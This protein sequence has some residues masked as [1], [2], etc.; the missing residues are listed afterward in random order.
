MPNTHHIQISGSRRILNHATIS[1]YFLCPYHY[2]LV[3]FNAGVHFHRYCCL[4][5][6]DQ[7]YGRSTHDSILPEAV[8]S[9]FTN[10]SGVHFKLGEISRSHYI[11]LEIGF[12]WGRREVAITTVCTALRYRSPWHSFTGNESDA[13]SASSWDTGHHTFSQISLS[14]YVRKCTNIGYRKVPWPYYYLHDDGVID[15]QEDWR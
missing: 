15:R 12:I 11:P 7:K 13:I 3:C 2:D 10:S 9:I 1:L 14:S 4:F 5:H 6:G 8:K